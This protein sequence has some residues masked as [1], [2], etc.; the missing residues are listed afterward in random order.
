MIGSLVLVLVV[1]ALVVRAARSPRLLYARPTLGRGYRV[2]AAC[3][4]WLAAQER[5]WKR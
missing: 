4:N 5:K 3:S 2:Y 1:A